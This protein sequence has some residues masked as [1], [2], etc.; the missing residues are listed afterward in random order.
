MSFDPAYLRDQAARCRRLAKSLLDPESVARLTE[1]ADSY[2]RDA[3]ALM[4]PRDPL[5]VPVIKA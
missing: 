4:T 2:D 5:E 1:L 3:A